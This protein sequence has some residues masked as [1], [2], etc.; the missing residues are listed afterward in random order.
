[1]LPLPREFVWLDMDILSPLK[2]TGLAEKRARF[3]MKF[4]IKDFFFE[5]NRQKHTAKK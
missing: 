2:K 3:G 4:I 1:M 5:I